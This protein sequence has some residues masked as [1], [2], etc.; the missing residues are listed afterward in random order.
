MYSRLLERNSRTDSL[1]S[2][3][4]AITKRYEIEICCFSFAL[5][6]VLISTDVLRNEHF[7]RLFSR[8]KF[9]QSTGVYLMRWQLKIA[10][11][12]GFYIDEALLYFVYLSTG[13]KNIRYAK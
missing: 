1:A 7:L 4:Y 2:L 6:L 10:Q 8:S 11:I 12:D 13:V 5:A 9:I 3:K